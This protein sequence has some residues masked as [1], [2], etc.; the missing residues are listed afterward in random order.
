MKKALAIV[1]VIVAL[2]LS[3]C[4]FAKTTPTD[5]VVV[6]LGEYKSKAVYHNGRIG[7]F[8]DYI[9]YV[10]E[11][12]SLVENDFFERITEGRK[13]ELITYIQNFEVWVGITKENNPDAELVLGYDFDVSFISDDD[14][15]YICDESGSFDFSLYKIYFFDMETMTLYF[16]YKCM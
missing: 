5:E 16:F 9:K 11:G 12:V 1:M 15:L 14:Y 6:S 8:T 2:C 13:E 4:S 3:A 7:D 10:Y